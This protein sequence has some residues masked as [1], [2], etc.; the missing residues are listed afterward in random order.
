MKI[1]SMDTAAL[2]KVIIKKTN[3]KNLYKIFVKYHEMPLE[4]A[5]WHDGMIKEITAGYDS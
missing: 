1:I 5:D 4:T 2:K 3:Y